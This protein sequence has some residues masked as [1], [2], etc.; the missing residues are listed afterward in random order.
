MRSEWF[1]VA[2]DRFY[3]HLDSCRR[4]ANKPFD[5][6]PEGAKLLK[7]AAVAD[8]AMNQNALIMLRRTGESGK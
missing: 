4:C 3:E 7:E 1:T 5:L 2:I 8:K 6:C